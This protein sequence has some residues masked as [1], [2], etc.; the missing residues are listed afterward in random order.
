PD[1]A[2]FLGGG[3]HRDADAVLDRGERVKELALAQDVGLGPGVMCQ[4]M[5]AD[6]RGRADRLDDAVIDAAAK[7]GMRHAACTGGVHAAPLALLNLEVAA[8]CGSAGDAG[9]VRAAAQLLEGQRVE[10][11]HHLL[12]QLHPQ[13]PHD[14]MAES[15]AGRVA[16]RILGGFEPAHRTHDVTEADPPALARQ[17]IA[18]ARAADPEEDLVPD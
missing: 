3:D 13:R 17:T 15:T 5:D 18:A 8:F 1:P 14:L 7:L 10:P 12:L 6:E 4:A 11:P 16:D 2:G 9:A